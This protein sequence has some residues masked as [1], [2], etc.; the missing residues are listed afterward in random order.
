[1]INNEREENI[2]GKLSTELTIK[3]SCLLPSILVLSKALEET[4]KIRQ[5]KNY[6]NCNRVTTANRIGF[7][8][9]NGSNL[10]IESIT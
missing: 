6:G 1:M 2:T 8:P 5:N 4:K 10:Q 3:K 7:K 9:C